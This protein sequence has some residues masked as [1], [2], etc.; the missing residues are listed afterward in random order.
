VPVAYVVLALIVGVHYRC[1]FVL[2]FSDTDI[3]RLAHARVG[4]HNNR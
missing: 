4:S 3:E 2:L 1:I